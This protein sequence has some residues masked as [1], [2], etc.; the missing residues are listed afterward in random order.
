MTG[1]RPP[2]LAGVLGAVALSLQAEPGL[3]ETLEAILRTAADTVPGV[4]YAS[5]SLVRRGKKIESVASTDERAVHADRLQY[6][7]GEGPCLDAVWQHATYRVGDLLGDDR[8]PRFGPAAVALGIRSVLS[9]QLFVVG[10]NLGALNLYSARPAAFG[11]E[12]EH[13]GAHF[14]THAA[15]ALAGSQREH[16]LDLAML[17]RD[18]IG[19]AK[20]ILMERHRVPGTR[21]FAMLVRASQDSNV[22]LREVAEHVVRD[23]ENLA[24]RRAVG[25]A[26]RRG[27]APDGRD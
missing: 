2:E 9:F 22:K 27:P 21:A 26:A 16:D 5:V 4:D 17:S 10:D 13:V 12:S 25:T 3:D 7:T 23:V 6:E 24:A 18:V 20:G 15:V 1:S 14:A 11:A 19:Q 8:W